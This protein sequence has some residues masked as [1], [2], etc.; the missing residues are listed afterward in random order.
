MLS[1]SEMRQRFVARDDLTT[2]LGTRLGGLLAILALIFGILAAITTITDTKVGSGWS[3]SVFGG[4]LSA[5]FV[6]G[7]LAAGF[8]ELIRWA[9]KKWLSQRA[10]PR[11]Q[12]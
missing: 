3:W 6:G 2:M 4:L 9:C 7:L 8:Y 10:S 1:E 5:T 12:A 11:H